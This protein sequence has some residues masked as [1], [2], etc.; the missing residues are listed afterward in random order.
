MSEPLLIQCLAFR[1]HACMHG[2]TVDFLLCLSS[3]HMFLST[4]YTYL[5]CRRQHTVL[6]T[7]TPMQNNLHE[8]Y[9]LLSY[10]HPNVFTNSAPFDDAFDLTNHKVSR[11]CVQ[12]ILSA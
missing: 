4:L 7:G 3:L 11:P 1:L 8:L 5:T 9:A 12:T 10:L 2:Y 6:L